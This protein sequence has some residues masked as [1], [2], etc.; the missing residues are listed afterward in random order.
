MDLLGR[1]HPYA[2]H[3]KA[4]K[5]DTMA[6]RPLPNNWVTTRF[7]IGDI[8]SIVEDE[9]VY[10]AWLNGGTGRVNVDASVSFVAEPALSNSVAGAAPVTTHIPPIH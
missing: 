4:V 2:L 10:L 3:E 1:R 7:T 6:F 9:V 5:V 8:V